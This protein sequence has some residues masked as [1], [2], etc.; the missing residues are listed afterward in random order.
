MAVLIFSC[1]QVEKQDDDGQLSTEIVN[2]PVTASGVKTN[3]AIPEIK[4]EKNI[5]NFGKVIQGERVSYSFKFKNT[6]SA[7]LIISGV[8][9]SCGCTVPSWSKKPIAPGDEGTIN[10]VFDS[11]GKKGR[12]NKAITVVT[13]SIPNTRV[14]NIVG[15]V[16]VPHGK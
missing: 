8:S 15:E 6:G 10:V 16:M 4:F 14:L 13:N 7:D 1:S 5:H 11:D 12:Q 2:N 3:K 9:A